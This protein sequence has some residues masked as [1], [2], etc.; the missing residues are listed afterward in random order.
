MKN[1]TR[2]DVDAARAVSDYDERRNTMVRARYEAARDSSGV[3][4]E[5][6]ALLRRAWVVSSDTFIRSANH[7]SDVLDAYHGW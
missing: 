1:V 2:L 4:E 6:V 5:E 7:Y 3:S